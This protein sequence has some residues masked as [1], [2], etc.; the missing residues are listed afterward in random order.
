MITVKWKGRAPSQASVTVP[1]NIHAIAGSA[2]AVQ[3]LFVVLDQPERTAPCGLLIILVENSR[4]A[5][6][7]EL[8]GVL[9]VIEAELTQIQRIG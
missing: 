4:H 2:A 7:V 8:E 3:C 6:Q 5:R 1:D 9:G